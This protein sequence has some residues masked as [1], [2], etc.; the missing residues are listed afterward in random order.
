MVNNMK[1][2]VR[3]RILLR[4]RTLYYKTRELREIVESASIEE[5]NADLWARID[6]YCSEL[7]EMQENIKNMMNR[8]QA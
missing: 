6:R 1:E 5:N 2:N 7:E 8:L 3:K 4:S